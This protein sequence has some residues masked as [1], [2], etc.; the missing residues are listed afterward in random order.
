MEMKKIVNDFDMEG[1]RHTVNDFYRE[2][3]YPKLES[4]LVVV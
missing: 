2:K 3:K 1:I 4:L